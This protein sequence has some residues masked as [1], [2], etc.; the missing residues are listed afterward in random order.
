MFNCKYFALSKR[1]YDSDTALSK[2]NFLVRMPKGMQQGS[3]HDD[4]AHSLTISHPNPG[5]LRNGT[6]STCKRKIGRLGHGMICSTGPSS[7]VPWW[8]HS[9]APAPVLAAALPGCLRLLIF[10]GCDGRPLRE[11]IL[12]DGAAVSEKLR[13]YKFVALE[14]E[15]GARRGVSS[16]PSRPTF[17][18][19]A[20]RILAAAASSILPLVM[21]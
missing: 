16:I 15:E 12:E 8:I 13:S 18:P 10:P 17:S 21:V 20:F 9:P 2:F 7:P 1:N 3:Y 14:V 5:P 19:L 11:V 6:S 4:P